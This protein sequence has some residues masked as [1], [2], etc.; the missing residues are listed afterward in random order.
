MSN[1]RPC[2]EKCNVLLIGG[3]GREHALAWKLS[4]SKKL[5]TLY[6]T[7]CK[8]GGIASLA[9][10]C[11]EQWSP[12]RSFFFSRWC[13]QHDIDLVVVGPE[14]PLAQGITDEITTEH[15]LVFG[16]SKAAA[17]IEADK[18]YAKE[19]MRQASIPTADS[20]S[21]TD[22]DA[23]RSYLM[24]GLDKELENEFKQELSQEVS[25]FIDWCSF[26][27]KSTPFTFSTELQTLLDNREDPCVVKASG[28]A[29]GKGVI[30]CKTVGEA[31][32]A[33]DLCMKEQA[34]G[35]AGGKIL[36]EE[37][38]TGNEVSVL[39]LVDGSTIWVLDICQDHKQVGEGDVGPNTGGM[40]AFCPAALLDEEMLLHVE[41]EI[42]VPAVDAMRRDG[43]EYRGV[44]YAGLMLTT[45]GPKVLEFNCRFGD[46]ETQPLMARFKGDLLDVLWR[47]ASGTLDGGEIDFEEDV[48]CC[49]VMCSEGYP[50]PY[51]K[52]QT[53]TGIETAE[54][55]G[56]IVVFHAGTDCSGKEL[57]TSGGRVL[58]VT[59]IAN[60]IE[61]AR[62]NANNACGLINFN[63]AFWRSDIG[64]RQ[65]ESINKKTSTIDAVSGA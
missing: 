42:L 27:E 38:M 9:T 64:C 2:P 49:V 52:G 36:I 55:S 51:V 48:S 25:S 35:D 33:V 8:N 24:R 28:L 40:G 53:I 59:A 31:L 1:T 46:P 56:D 13:D 17:R 16:P 30:I 54:A 61:E 39:A 7:D 3:G 14:V 63:G 20:R 44:L 4:Q 29:A 6:A 21:F 50:G 10:S 22:I 12:S 11:D 45:A 57:V 62:T 32:K 58:G 23:A 41:R 60:S 65:N 19:L 43:I 5:G 26:R 47:T 37:F 18:T 34:F 15:R